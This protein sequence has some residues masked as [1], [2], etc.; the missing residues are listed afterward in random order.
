M[1]AVLTRLSNLQSFVLPEVL[2]VLGMLF[3]KNAGKE[4][5]FMRYGACAIGTPEAEKVASE[6]FSVPPSGAS[7]LFIQNANMFYAAGGF[8]FILDR[9]ETDVIMCVHADFKV[10]LWVGLFTYTMFLFHCG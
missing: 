4:S 6:A 2:E 9:L 7:W 5:F 3:L 1:Q 8:D 10:C